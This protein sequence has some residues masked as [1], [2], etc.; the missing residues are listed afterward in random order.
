MPEQLALVHTFLQTAAETGIAT[1]E[2]PE[3][4]R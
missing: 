4:E 3:A 1:I 2:D